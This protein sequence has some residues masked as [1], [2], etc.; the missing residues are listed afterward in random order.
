[1]SDVQE[2]ISIFVT[3]HPRFIS[4]WLSDNIPPQQD[5]GPVLLSTPHINPEASQGGELGGKGIFELYVE[6]NWFMVWVMGPLV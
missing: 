2:S 5:N 4:S 1:M 3:D 6:V